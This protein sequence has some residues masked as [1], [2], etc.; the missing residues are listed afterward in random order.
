MI[1]DVLA[2][3]TALG[4]PTKESLLLIEDDE[5]L[6]S[7]FRQILEGA[8]YEVV[9]ACNGREGLRRYLAT[10]ADVIITD[11]LMPEQEGLETIE[12]LRQY[13]PAAKIVAI[14]GGGRLETLDYLRVAKQLGAQIVLRKPFGRDELLEAVHE[15]L[16]G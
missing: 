13:N 8:G 14:S 15:V 9:E 6:R 1:Q 10:P 2:R 12:A 7:I 4:A 3:R 11:L 5:Q 16:Q